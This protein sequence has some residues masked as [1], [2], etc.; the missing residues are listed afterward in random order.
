MTTEELGRVQV[1]DILRSPI[2]NE[3]KVIEIKRGVDRKT[4][5]AL[6]LGGTALTSKNCEAW[7]VVE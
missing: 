6:F 1:G 5:K 3:M 7:E 2:G 4:T